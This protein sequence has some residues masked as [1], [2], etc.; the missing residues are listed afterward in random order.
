MEGFFIRKNNISLRG[1]PNYGG[2]G[3][4]RVILPLIVWRFVWRCAFWSSETDT[5]VARCVEESDAHA[6]HRLRRGGQARRYS[7]RLIMTSFRQSGALTVKLNVTASPDA[8]A[9][10]V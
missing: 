10:V 8:P 3:K 5:S 9:G 1:T 4:Y 2:S 7:S 6:G